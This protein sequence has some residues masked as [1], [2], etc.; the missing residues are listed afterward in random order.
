M[1]LSKLKANSG[2]EREGVPKEV[3]AVEGCWDREGHFSLGN[4]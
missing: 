3:F 4:S 1:E 2:I